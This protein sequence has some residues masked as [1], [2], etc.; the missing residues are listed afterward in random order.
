MTLSV[1]NFN[2]ACTPSQ[3]IVRFPGGSGLALLLHS[4]DSIRQTPRAAGLD[5]NPRLMQ[6]TI[7]APPGVLG[8]ADPAI[9]AFVAKYLTGRFTDAP[10]DAAAG[11]LVFRDQDWTLRY[12]SPGR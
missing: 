10:F 3:L 6:G 7:E 11:A 1:L 8:S 5:G 2:L 9:Q 4:V 12:V